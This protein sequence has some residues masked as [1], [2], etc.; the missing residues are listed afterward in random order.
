MANLTKGQ[1]VRLGAFVGAGL[2][3]LIGATLLLA[4]RALTEKRDNYTVLFSNKSASF[5]GLSVGS[6]VSYSGIKIGR[7][8][9]LGIQDKDVS[10]IRVTISVTS[11]TAIA[12]D[13]K[14]SLGSQGITGM[15]FID[16]S[17]GSTKVALRKP[18]DTIP[19]GDSMLDSLAE[20]AGSIGEKL[21]D[22]MTHM[23]AMTGEP[24]QKQLQQILDQTAGILTDNRPNIAAIIENARKSTEQLA[25]LT[26]RGALVMD[27]ADNLL[28]DLGGTTKEL[29]KSL[30]LRSEV[31]TTLGKA[32]KVL[33][34]LS[35][36]VVRSQ[37]D[38]DVT[39]RHLRDAAADLRDFSQAV[40]DNPTLLMFSADHASDRRI[41]K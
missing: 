34:G 7:V 17:R 10:V 37:G 40:K 13:S 33:D 30:S 36:V 15:K 16:I 22:L 11:G 21:D 4:G 12:I 2:T 1:K 20:R 8:E 28:T 35:L 26:A 6:D 32:D 5:S 14:A 39:L 9:T 25:L 3:V 19:A 23:Q 27:H 24:A 41:G 18:N 38:I 29:R 31:E